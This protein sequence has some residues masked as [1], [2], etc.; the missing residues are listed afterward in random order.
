ML[1]PG[2]WLIPAVPFEAPVRRVYHI[3]A[4]EGVTSFWRHIIQYPPGSVSYVVS[5]ISL[6]IATATDAADS[7]GPRV[8]TA[9]RRIAR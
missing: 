5:F 3:D 6:V 4:A 1:G 2:F 9:T 7:V 8:S